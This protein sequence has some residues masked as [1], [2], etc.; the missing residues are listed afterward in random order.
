MPRLKPRQDLPRLK[1]RQDLPVGLPSL[2]GPIICPGN[3][4]SA[5]ASLGC[6]GGPFAQS[7]AKAGDALNVH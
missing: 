1:P 5:G 4:S 6:L 7:C 3:F 2:M